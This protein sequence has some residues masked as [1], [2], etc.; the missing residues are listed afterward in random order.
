MTRTSIALATLGAI[1][2]TGC[3]VSRAGVASRA[4]RVMLGMTKAELF[5][6]AGVPAREAQAGGLE[7]LTY[8]G[9]GD[10]VSVAYSNRATRRAGYA[11]GRTAQRYCEATFVLRD[12]VIER[13]NY[14]GRTGGLLTGGEQCAFIVENCVHQRTRRPRAARQAGPADGPSAADAPSRASPAPR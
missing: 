14:S 7:F 9:G 13:V 4:Q 2:V 3:V 12:D 10:S 6:C 1:A 11:V 8:S 5:I